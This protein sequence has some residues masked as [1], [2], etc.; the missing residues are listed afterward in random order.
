M[1]ANV[2]ARQETWSSAV[3]PTTSTMLD[4]WALER[5]RGQSRPRRFDS[6]SGTDSSCRPPP[7][8]PWRPSSSRTAKRC[9][10]GCG[11]RCSISAKPTC[12]A[13]WRYAANSS[14]RSRPSIAR[15]ALLKAGS[16]GCGLSRTA[17]DAGEQRTSTITTIWA[18]SSIASGWTGKWST[19]APIFR[20]P[21][22]ARG[23]ADRQDGSRVPE[24]VR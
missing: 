2:T 14:R 23:S 13:P 4:R 1:R 8:P 18:T 11:I 5:I 21:T 24:A 15:W 7:G 9:S 22:L 16:G 12:S 17:C 3:V 6:R 20:R 10:A 19:R